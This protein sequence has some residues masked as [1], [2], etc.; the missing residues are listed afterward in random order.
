MSNNSSIN[1]TKTTDNTEY[2]TATE[3]EVLAYLKEIEV[4][5]RTSIGEEA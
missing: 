5:T 1:N 3:I 2:A 4:S